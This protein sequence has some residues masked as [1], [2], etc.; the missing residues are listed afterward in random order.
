MKWIKQRVG[1]S[2][3]LSRRTHDFLCIQ[4]AVLYNQFLSLNFWNGFH[5]SVRVTYLPSLHENHT[6]VIA[7]ERCANSISL[8]HIFGLFIF[9]LTTFKIRLRLR[10]VLRM[11]IVFGSFAVC[12]YYGC[13]HTYTSIKKSDKILFA[14]LWPPDKR[15][16]EVPTTLCNG[17]MYTHSVLIAHHTFLL[18]RVLLHARVLN[19]VKSH[20]ALVMCITS[21]RLLIF[22][23]TVHLRRFPEF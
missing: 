12:I 18:W 20:L 19:N 7:V 10:L 6:L 17:L 9:M 22:F 11:F 23:F 8:R 13:I 21:V 1:F 14:C 5:F 16:R 15:A 2:I 3:N 4:I